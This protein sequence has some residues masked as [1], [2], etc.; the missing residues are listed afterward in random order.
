MTTSGNLWFTYRATAL[1]TVVLLSA[2]QSSGLTP[3]QNT[4][5]G[6]VGAPASP[7]RPQAKHAHYSASELKTLGG[8]FGIGDGINNRGWV[9][10]QSGLSSGVAHAALWTKGQI[11]D[12]GTLGGPNS[13]VPFPI[14]SNAGDVAGAS[15]T[16]IIDPYGENFCSDNVPQTC[17]AFDWRAGVMSALPTLGGNN[18]QADGNNSGG[19]IVGFAE[20]ATLDPSCVA[21]QVL[22]IGAT[23]WDRRTHRVTQL[24]NL[25]GDVI[26]GAFAVNDRGDVVGGGGPACGPP[27]PPVLAHAILW[28]HGGSPI[29]LPGLGG[30]M[31]NA[32]EAINNRGDIAGGSDLPGD[33]AGHA[34]LW[35]NGKMTDLGTLPGDVSSDAFGINSKDQIVGVSVDASGNSRAVLWENG[36]IYD[37]NTLIPPSSNLYL[38]YGGDI[39]DAG[40]IAGQAMDL[41]TGNQPAF[42]ASPHGGKLAAPTPRQKL[43]LPERIRELMTRGDFGRFHFGFIRR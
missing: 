34:V 7:A 39:N 16:T 22:D 37:L 9:T 42:Q 13:Y 23:Q 21:P 24:P 38:I 1:A 10:G 41:T 32:G 8:S 12:L 2:C 18:G 20:T 15:D 43:V 26:A 35:K 25:P 31:N 3:P 6:P 29:S 40:V 30:A 27:A 19:D 28:R 11:V 4:A 33:T 17:L 14:K 36:A 5:V